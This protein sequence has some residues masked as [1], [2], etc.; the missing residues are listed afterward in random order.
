M[1]RPVVLKLTKGDIAAVGDTAAVG[2]IV[3]IGGIAAVGDIAAISDIAGIC[4][5]VCSILYMNLCLAQHY[6][7]SST[8]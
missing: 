5:E 3:A 2:D 7:A 1:R 6:H 4:L 8:F